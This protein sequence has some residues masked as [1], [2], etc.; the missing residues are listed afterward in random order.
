MKKILFSG[1]DIEVRFNGNPHNKKNVIIFREGGGLP[2]I[3]KDGTKVLDQFFNIIN[4]E[5][6]FVSEDVNE[7]Y[8]DA[9]H[10]HIYETQ[11]MNSAIQIIKKNILP[12]SINVTFGISMGGT[13]AVNFSKDLNATF[14]AFGPRATLSG[15]LPLSGKAEMYT[16][17]YNIQSSNVERGLCEKSYGYIFFDFYHNIDRIHA[18][19]IKH[20]TKAKIFNYPFWGHVNIYKFSQLIRLKDLVYNILNDKFDLKYIKCKMHTN[21]YKDSHPEYIYFLIK[22]YYKNNL[23]KSLEE[24]LSD[25]I[26][27]QN[28]KHL[29]YISNFLLKIN[30]KSSFEFI[31]KSY[32]LNKKN[33]TTKQNIFRYFT[34]FP[35]QL[36]YTEF[37]FLHDEICA[38]RAYNEGNEKKTLSLFDNIYNKNFFN[39]LS[40]ILYATSL[41]YHNRIDDAVTIIR[42]GLEKYPNS[43]DIERYNTCLSIRTN[44]IQETSSNILGSYLFI[45]GN[46]YKIV[47]GNLTSSNTY[48]SFIN[49]K[50]N[51]YLRHYYGKLIESEKTPYSIF[52]FDSSFIIYRIDNN[53]VLLRCSNLNLTNMFVYY[54]GDNICKICNFEDIN[55]I[56]YFTFDIFYQK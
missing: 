6:F 42:N 36:K 50:N 32:M 17:S 27:L 25:K 9:F 10:A 26:E 4:Y 30:N 53:K 22:Y 44:L 21:Y 31:K 37:E 35:D 56:N 19:Y 28:V 39:P 7:F 52:N 15:L 51:K 16:K 38:C 1:K 49:C 54:K 46:M 8:I 3:L 2:V 24:F 20:H 12:D 41:E 33:I 5:G 18:L 11:E 34:K 55:N 45:L 48:Y 14:V 13:A 29:N 47:K 43:E 40:Y 23:K